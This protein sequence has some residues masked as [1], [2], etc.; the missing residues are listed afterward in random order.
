MDYSIVYSECF[1][2]YRNPIITS[3]NRNLGESINVCEIK[4][5]YVSGSYIVNLYVSKINRTNLGI[6]NVYALLIYG[7]IDGEYSIAIDGEG[8]IKN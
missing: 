4:A 7:Y 2:E 5:N 3:W 1:P 6:C 8:A